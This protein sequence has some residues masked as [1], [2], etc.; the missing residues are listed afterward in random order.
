MEEIIQY[1]F[2][3]EKYFYE[4]IHDKIDSYKDYDAII[5]RNQKEIEE[6]PIKIGYFQNVIIDSPT[7]SD[8]NPIIIDEKFN[9]INLVVRGKSYVILKCTKNK[10]VCTDNTFVQTR[11]DSN[12]SLYIRTY[13]NSE[14][15]IFTNI[16][17]SAY[18]NSKIHVFSDACHIN[19]YDGVSINIYSKQ[20]NGLIKCHSSY[21]N[22]WYN[23][24]MSLENAS[25]IEIFEQENYNKFSHVKISTQQELDSVPIDYTGAV[26]I[27]S[28][29]EEPIIVK[30]KI[31]QLYIVGKSSTI[32]TFEA[33]EEV[34]VYVEDQSLVAVYNNARI[35]ARHNS[36]INNYSS[37]LV[38]LSGQAVIMNFTK[39]ANII[40]NDDN[41]VFDFAGAES[42][43]SNKFAQ[44]KIVNFKS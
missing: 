24:I 25:T 3:K 22:T 31:H 13:D 21:V 37:D 4:I 20:F 19:A 42:I 29:K 18:N 44:Y 30:Q 23:N 26:F 43:D 5:I 8:V 1:H 7:S 38:E 33:D 17:I 11:V 9:N 35:Y 28:N 6:F 32:L 15:T 27:N 2:N 36:I 10:I 41:T 40:C 34:Y 39:K 14:L 16:I 12:T